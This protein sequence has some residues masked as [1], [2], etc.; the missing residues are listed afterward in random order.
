MQYY[1]DTLNEEDE[2]IEPG[3]LDPEKLEYAEDAIRKLGQHLSEI[4]REESIR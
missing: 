3:T 4:T 1:L 2:E